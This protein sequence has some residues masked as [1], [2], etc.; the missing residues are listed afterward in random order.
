[1]KKLM[2]IPG[3][4]P[5]D[6][7]ILNALSKDT[8]S[9]LDPEFVKILKETLEDLKTVVMTEKGQ[10]FI[11][12]GT[13]TLGMEVA[14][15]NS[16][17]KGDRLLVISHGFFGDRFVEIA[18]CYGIEVEVLASEWGKIVEVEEIAQKLKEK[19]FD[20][21]TLSHVDTSTGVCTPLKEV[22]EILEQ[23]PETVF[24]VDGVCATGG[25]EERMDDWGIDI[26]FTGNQKAF[27]VPPGL[28]NAI[29]N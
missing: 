16:L 23:F 5:V 26:L 10:P 4:T 2:M 22:G 7:S 25:I 12:P 14:I 27:G 6:Q 24:I 17:K 13:G 1:M 20:A 15:V 19:K 11:I 21:I 28:A 3:P 9:H 8:V 18:Q 29:F